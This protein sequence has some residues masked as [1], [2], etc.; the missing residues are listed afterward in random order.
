MAEVAKKAG[1]TRTSLYKSLAD[2]GSPRFSTISR[3]AHAL[4][5]KISISQA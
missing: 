5:C 2:G 3:I 1:L 4:G